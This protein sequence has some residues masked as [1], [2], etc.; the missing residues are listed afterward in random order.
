ML[1]NTSSKNKPGYILLYKK[2]KTQTRPTRDLAQWSELPSCSFVCTAVYDLCGAAQL[3]E[4][5][6]RNKTEWPQPVTL[7]RSFSPLIVPVIKVVS[8]GFLGHR[9]T[10]EESTP[11]CF[12]LWFCLLRDGQFHLLRAFTTG[13]IKELALV[14]SGREKKKARVIKCC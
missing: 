12:N 14:K 13:L 9:T 10:P 1:Q 5:K 7:K 8:P 4:R 11:T 2:K 3:Q 6:E